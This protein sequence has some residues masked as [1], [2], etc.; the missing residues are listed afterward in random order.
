MYSVVKNK[1]TI[2]KSLNIAFTYK[3]KTLIFDV[4]N[5]VTPRARTAIEENT[6]FEI[7]NKFIK[8][9]GDKFHKELFEK[10]NEIKELL[11]T[12]VLSDSVTPLPTV[13]VEDILDMFD[14]VEL[15]EF[16]S[17][18]RLSPIPT[19]LK[20]SYDPTTEINDLGSR[21]QTYLKDDYYDL[22]ALINILRATLLT[23]GEYVTMK[24]DS[25]SQSHK[26]YLMI[27]FYIEHKIYETPAFIKLRE[28]IN[29]LLE[30]AISKSEEFAINIITSNIPKRE[31][32][33]YLLGLVIFQKFILS[34]D[35]KDEK[36]KNVVTKL[37]H[38]VTNKIGI[39]SQNRNNKLSIKTYTGNT[40]SA[41][42]EGESALESFRV[43]T[44]ITPGQLVEFNYIFADPYFLLQQ[45]GCNNK[46]D[47]KLLEEVLPYFN[48]LRELD[49]PD[50]SFIIMSWV[51]KDVIDP[52][53]IDYIDLDLVHGLAV[54]YVYLNKIDEG[55]FATLL[56]TYISK[57]DNFILS[58]NLKHKITK[59]NLEILEKFY[60][61][62]KAVRSKD[63]ITYSNIILQSITDLVG[64]ISNKNLVS[65]LPDKYSSIYKN[66]AGSLVIP[67]NIRNDIIT[68]IIKLNKKEEGTSE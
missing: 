32:I 37:Y 23:I 49:I 50:E 63:K 67:N 60:P 42:T 5:A 35:I 25:I 64:T 12:F 30:V 19:M 54:A 66:T 55:F 56:S 16:I 31:F 40:N 57:K 51:L 46:E 39:K 33:P 41:N 59:E 4:T 11:A 27:H 45:V 14:I 10:Y 24:K 17:K 20:D 62:H 8:Y 48:K 47:I 9:K 21:E 36:D 58:V 7:L 1:S 22:I 61:N 6:L 38:F 13:I 68:M 53:V 29:K 52:R 26:E 15:K 34:N 3:D 18:N 2:D 44:D 65:V 28:Y 43:S